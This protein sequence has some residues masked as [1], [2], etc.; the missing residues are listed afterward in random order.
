[1]SLSPHEIESQELGCRYAHGHTVVMGLGMG[2]AAI[3]VALNPAVTLVTVIERDPDMIA[4][5]KGSPCLNNL[6]EYVFRKILIIQGNALEWVPDQPVDFLYANIWRELAEPQI[7]SDV[8][9]MQA[10]VQ[11]GTIYF[12]G[13]E[14]VIHAL[15]EKTCTPATDTASRSQ[16]V[17]QCVRERIALPL[18]L[19]AS[20]DYPDLIAQVVR[21]PVERGFPVPRNLIAQRLSLRPFTDEDMPFLLAAY[22]ASRKDEKDLFGWQDAQWEDFISMQFEFQHTQY[23]RSYCNPSFDIIICDNKPAG[24]L[25]VD[26]AGTEIRVIDIIIMPEFRRQGIAAHLFAG[27]ISEADVAGIP[28]SLHVEHN[29]PIMPYY[30]RLGFEARADREIYQYMERG[31]TQS[32]LQQ[33]DK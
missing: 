32:A 24:R 1:M 29:N 16:Q 5:F 22:A 11:A 31:P 12:W 8:R 3:N 17:A 23:M 7:L 13:Q 25:Y 2:W 20:L 19:P 9:R 15:V 33:E 18:L 30:K 27:L 10:N 28:L 21:R 4:L 26:R 14:L 6:P